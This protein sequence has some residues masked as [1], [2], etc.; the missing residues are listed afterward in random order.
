MR[1]ISVWVKSHLAY[2]RLLWTDAATDKWRWWFLACI[3]AKG[4]HFNIFVIM[5]KTCALL[6][7][8]RW[9][10]KHFTSSCYIFW[11]KFSTTTTLCRFC[12]PKIIDIDHYLLK[13]FENIAIMFKHSGWLHFLDQS[14]AESKDWVESLIWMLIFGLCPK[15]D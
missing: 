9:I 4:C 14:F 15:P 8:S 10:A 5:N 12:V 3:N 13:F 1:L 6:T 11:L 7:F 2:S